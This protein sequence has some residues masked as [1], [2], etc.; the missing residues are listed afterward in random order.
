[1]MKINNNSNGNGNTRKKSHL[2][3]F[4]RTLDHI[5]GAGRRPRTIGRP[6]LKNA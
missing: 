6:P 4:P 2:N 5:S 1:M 3:E